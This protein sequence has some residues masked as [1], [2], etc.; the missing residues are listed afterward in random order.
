MPDNMASSLVDSFLSSVYASVPSQQKKVTAFYA[1]TPEAREELG[2]FLSI[3]QPVWQQ[4]EI[5][6]LEGLAKAYARMLDEVMLCRKDFMRSGTYSMASQ[7]DAFEHVYNN[8]DQMLP[9][10][11]GLAVSQYLW[12]S[13]Y[14]ILSFFKRCVSVQN[15]S[16]RFLEVGSGHGIFLNYLA[17]KT[18]PGA[19]IE[20]VDISS[21]SIAL[22]KNLLA[23]TNPD[24]AK[25]IPFFESDIA[26]YKAQKPYDFIVM[27][28]VL[29]HVESPSAVLQSLKVLLSE[30]GSL[31]VTTCVNCP[32]IDHVYLF[33]HV[34][35]IR[36][37]ISSAGFTIADEVVIPSEESKSLEYHVKH[38]LDILYAA[39]LK[40]AK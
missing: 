28:E 36:A 32:A 17:G 33:N 20:V 40:K 38:K 8:H 31:Y 4:T 21:V 14:Q 30:N 15:P 23:A 18:S 22:S 2:V 37:L 6:G 1:A 16:G 34:D 13:H 24:A 9:Y 10:M 29:E 19:V 5:G 25:R 27:G 11:L 39:L 3:Y 35:E 12:Q 26:H 7:A